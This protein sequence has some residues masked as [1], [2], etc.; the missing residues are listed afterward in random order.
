M[1][2]GIVSQHTWS[3]LLQSISN[4]RK[5]GALELDLGEQMTLAVHF[6]QGKIVDIQHGNET[7]ATSTLRLLKHCKL[8]D[9]NVEVEA[10]TY[11]N[12]ENGLTQLLGSEQ[13]TI[14]ELI[15]R[16]VFKRTLD[17]LHEFR[18]DTTV[19][20]SFRV[21]GFEFGREAVPI[22]VSQLLL[23]L[24]DYEPVRKDFVEKFSE[25]S[26]IVA[27]PGFVAPG[28]DMSVILKRLSSRSMK[29]NEL[30]G[31]LL[32]PK[33]HA[34]RAMLELLAV[35]GLLIGQQGKA[36]VLAEQAAPDLI[37]GNPQARAAML[38]E[39][40]ARFTDSTWIPNII[41]LIFLF[42]SITVPFFFWEGAFTQF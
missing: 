16:A 39:L 19:P 2:S 32:L 40:A 25:G 14:R 30:L 33:L 13:D 7:P 31:E 9:V 29:P 4:K 41:A 6:L 36:A 22:A 11:A 21:G 15:R 27:A 26:R 37:M 18:L 24:A 5:Q 1:L 35:G 42:A 8:V 3:Q 12:L 23:D 34:E 28:D 20:W 10:G 38:R 17:T